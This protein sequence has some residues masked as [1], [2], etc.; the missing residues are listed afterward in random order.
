MPTFSPA[1]WFESREFAFPMHCITY[2]YQN[3]SFFYPPP[4][5][6]GNWQMDPIPKRVINA[7][8]EPQPMLLCPGFKCFITQGS[9]DIFLKLKF[10][11]LFKRDFL[12]KKSRLLQ[13]V[14]LQSSQKP[15]TA[16]AIV[17]MKVLCAQISSFQVKIRRIFVTSYT[18]TRNIPLDTPAGAA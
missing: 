12:L 1:I 15:N 14:S 11:Q 16:F 4:H 5:F 17:I 10:L 18:H 3:K 13:Q 9:V 2:L 6:W 8:K 7:L